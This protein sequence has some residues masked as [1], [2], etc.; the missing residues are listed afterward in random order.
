[1]RKRR[2]Q[3]PSEQ[4]PAPRLLTVIQVAAML[5]VGKDTVYSLI[6]HEGLPAMSISL[7]GTRSKLRVSVSSLEQWIRAREQVYTP[8]MGILTNTQT[9]VGKPERKRQVRK[10][11][12]ESEGNIIPLLSKQAPSQPS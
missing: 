11:L 3:A 9:D 1:M 8:S 2:E 12:L 7:V 10:G 6:K 5:S 4:A